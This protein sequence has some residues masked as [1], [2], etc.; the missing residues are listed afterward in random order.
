MVLPVKKPDYL[1]DSRW[2]L[3]YGK[4]NIEARI[5]DEDWLRRFQR[6]EID[7]RPGDALHCLV[8]TEVRYGHDNELL[9]ESFTVARVIAVLPILDADL[10]LPFGG[11]PRR[12]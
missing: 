1:G 11:E 12:S 3:R 4:R 2:Q 10:D 6:R 9:T 8:E 5:L 7:V